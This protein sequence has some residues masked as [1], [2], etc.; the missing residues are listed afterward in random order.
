VHRK[1]GGHSDWFKRGPLEGNG[2]DD[3]RRYRLVPVPELH[4]DSDADPSRLQ[5]TAAACRSNELRVRR[6]AE[7]ITAA[8][9]HALGHGFDHHE[10]IPGVA[11]AHGHDRPCGELTHVHAVRVTKLEGEAV[12]RACTG[13]Q[14]H[15]GG[16]AFF[17]SVSPFR[18][19]SRHDALEQKQCK[20]P[21]RYFPANCGRIV[22][23]GAKFA[24]YVGKTSHR[25]R[26]PCMAAERRNIDERRA[27]TSRDGSR[28]GFASLTLHFPGVPYR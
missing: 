24:S 2:V 4:S 10:T 18:D 20:Q 9:E 12:E 26:L 27:N 17:W 7:P 13:D 3:G 11:G 25:L 8:N 23:Q 19:G 15:I 28:D 5:H 14:M 1:A 16:Y 21:A 6:L 22:R